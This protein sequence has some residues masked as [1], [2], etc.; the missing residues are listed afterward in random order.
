VVAAPPPLPP[1][2]PELPLVVLLPPVVAALDEPEVVLPPVFV[3]VFGASSDEQ[4]DRA[5]KAPAPSA[6]FR[7]NVFF[8][9]F[10]APAG[11]YNRLKYEKTY[12]SPP[13]QANGGAH[14]GRAGI[15]SATLPVSSAGPFY[16]SFI[17]WGVGVRSSEDPCC[18]ELTCSLSPAPSC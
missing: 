18:D 13:D 4:P 9:G 7:R 8:T 16:A 1:V 10:L 5:M 11:R 3:V 14:S 17:R 2:A 15:G 6:R 12:F